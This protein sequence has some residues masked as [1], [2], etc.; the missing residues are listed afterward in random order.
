MR[1]RAPA[2][3]PQASYPV[4]TASPR[5]SVPTAA[6]P[7]RQRFRA[8]GAPAATPCRGRSRLARRCDHLF[9]PSCRYLVLT[10]FYRAT[11]YGRLER[12]LHCLRQRGCDSAAEKDMKIYLL[13]LLIGA[14]L[15]AV[16]FTS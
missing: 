16:Q 8:E 14:I 7:A 2:R 15:T 1:A 12:P 10:I 3:V 9:V 6:P 5:R 4:A 13:V 11:I